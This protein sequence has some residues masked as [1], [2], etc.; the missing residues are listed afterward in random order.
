MC[1]NKIKTFFDWDDLRK[2]NFSL[3]KKVSY[4]WRYF[5]SILFLLLFLGSY[6]LIGFLSGIGFFLKLLIFP[7]LA[8]IFVF[9]FFIYLF[10]ILATIFKPSNWESMLY[11][12]NSLASAIKNGKFSRI[13][14]FYKK[15]LFSIKHY[16][17]TTKNVFAKEILVSL[18]VYLKKVLPL[19]LISRRE[20][21]RTKIFFGLKKISSSEDVNSLYESLKLFHNELVKSPEFENIYLIDKVNFYDFDFFI[22]Y[23]KKDFRRNKFLEIFHLIMSYIQEHFKAFGVILIFVA[24]CLGKVNQINLF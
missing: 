6:F 14:K 18:Y 19:L 10:F 9:L 2:Y 4:N 20:E 22:E 17:S 7:L 8:Y 13:N 12:N 15:T 24:I 11:F 16:S 23:L 3:S 1:W 21:L 5:F